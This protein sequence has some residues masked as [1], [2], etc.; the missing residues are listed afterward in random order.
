[1]KN[2]KVI[3]ASLAVVGVLAGFGISAKT[4]TGSQGKDLKATS[5]EGAGPSFC[6]LYPALCVGTEGNGGGK[7]PGKDKK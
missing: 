1:M 2:Q 7:E 3:V 6:E 4:D 5:E